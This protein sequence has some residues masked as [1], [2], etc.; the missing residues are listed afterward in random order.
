[1]LVGFEQEFSDERITLSCMVV[2]IEMLMVNMN[3][4]KSGNVIKQGVA[5]REQM[6]FPIL[7]ITI[8]L[9]SNL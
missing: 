3:F 2:A 9:T 1:M 7:F 6:E 5:Q 8:L 4:S